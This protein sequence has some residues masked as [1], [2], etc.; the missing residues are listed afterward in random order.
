MYIEYGN[1]VDNLIADTKPAIITKGIK[2]LKDNGVFAR[3]TV[4]GKITASKV[5]VAVDK[6]KVDGSEVPYCILTDDVD[7]TGA[8]VDVTTTGYLSGSFQ[9]SNLIFGGTDTADDHRAALRDKNI[10]LK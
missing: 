7:T 8:T 1:E 10:Y 2:L 5:C 6:S 9:E 4:L 3:G